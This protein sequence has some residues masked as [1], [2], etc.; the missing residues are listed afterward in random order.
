MEDITVGN[1]ELKVV[2][3]KNQKTVKLTIEQSQEDWQIQLAF[4][5]QKYRDWKLNG[6]KINPKKVGNFD[7]FEGKG[8]KM[9]LECQ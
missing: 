9:E 5:S 1:N 2:Y 3:G 8:R 6:Q 7:V 4:P